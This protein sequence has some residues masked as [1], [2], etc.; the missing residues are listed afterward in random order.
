MHSIKR[1]VDALEE[2]VCWNVLR[3]IVQEHLSTDSRGPDILQ[4]N[5]EILTRLLVVQSMLRLT[6]EASYWLA[7]DSRC[8]S[9]FVGCPI[10]AA[11]DYRYFR[12]VLNDT[13]GISPVFE[14]LQNQL[15]EQ[16][17]ELVWGEFKFPYLTEYVA[18]DVDAG[19][20]KVSVRPLPQQALTKGPTE[21]CY[22]VHAFV[23]ERQSNKTSS[24][25]AENYSKERFRE[26]AGFNN[27]RAMYRVLH[28]EQVPSQQELDGMASILGKSALEVELLL[29][30]PYK[31]FKIKHLDNPCKEPR[32]MAGKTCWN[33]KL[34]D[35][36]YQIVLYN[37]LEQAPDYTHP[38]WEALRHKRVPSRD[39]Y[40]PWE[41]GVY[42][43]YESVN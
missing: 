12:Q 7:E 34:Q 26:Y 18:D 19:D 15:R 20:E 11:A 9:E 21:L 27:R 39:G 22:V 23:K 31:H 1:V 37:D 42:L 3:E 14:A 10:P 30:N 8:V 35:W 17:Q 33:P 36:E 32:S 5:T 6:D 40:V 29:Y 24:G 2:Q 16:G 43:Y 41:T 13:C 4:Q 28:G 38:V 25:L